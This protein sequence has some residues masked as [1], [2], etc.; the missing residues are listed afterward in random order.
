VPLGAS[1]GQP[2][3]YTGEQWDASAGLVYLRARYLSPV[4]GRFTSKDP[5]PGFWSQPQTLNRFVYVG[6][7]PIN[8]SDP[9]GLYRKEV[10]FQL[11]KEWAYHIAFGDNRS[12]QGP[13]WPDAV[14]ASM[15]ARE[16]AQ[17]D[18]DVDDI[19]SMSPWPV[20]GQ[21]RK[22]HFATPREA[23]EAIDWAIKKAEGFLEYNAQAEQALREFGYA[24]HMLQDT[25]SHWREGYVYRSDYED[26]PPVV[27][28]RTGH[29]LHS[30]Q[31]KERWLHLDLWFRVDEWRQDLKEK[32]PEARGRIDQLGKDDV[33]DLW[34]RELG[35]TEEGKEYRYEYGYDTDKYFEFSERDKRMRAATEDALRRFF[36]AFGCPGPEI[37]D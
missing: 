25:Y 34:I 14:R 30:T 10:H 27:M 3:G 35:V 6:N 31:T 18:Q 22:M 19:R 21:P 4:V 32:Y 9:S 37:C 26:E 5:F 16:I 33:V 2:Y 24:L 28:E 23:N 8:R 29:G 36:D 20:V 7:N 11:T 1:G 13:C 17:A 15:Y 12:F